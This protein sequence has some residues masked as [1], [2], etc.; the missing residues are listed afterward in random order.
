ME[1][2]FNISLAKAG[3]MLFLMT[4][5]LFFLSYL[6]I[7]ACLGNY[8]YHVMFIVLFILRALY[9]MDVQGPAT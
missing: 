8:K 5:L 6:F 4:V 7:G 9:N 3:K 2:D 1:L